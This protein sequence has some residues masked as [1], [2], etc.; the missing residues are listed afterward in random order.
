MGGQ[1]GTGGTRPM[2]TN[3]HAQTAVPI[4]MYHSIADPPGEKYQTWSVRPERFDRQMAWLRAHDFSPM[5]VT[6]L[7]ATLRDPSA[8]LPEKPVL[9]TFDDGFA[10][11]HSAALPILVA[12]NIPAT[13]YVTTGYVGGTSEWLN[14]PEHHQ[15]M[16]TW[17]QLAEVS[18]S[19]VEIGAHTHTHPELDT[20]PYEEAQDEITRPKRILE[21]RLGLRV[22][23]FAYPHGYHGPT[24]KRLVCEA[25]YTSACGVKHAMSA[26]TDDC[27]SLAR[28]IVGYD[29]DM[30]E[31]ASLMAGR[32]LE[33][34]PRGEK[35]VTV[36]WRVARRTRAMTRRY[37]S[38][39]PRGAEAIA[40]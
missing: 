33:I 26:T 23:S 25:G 29:V 4:L 13:L 6:G 10:D 21:D 20:L 11:F 37:A 38:R 7:V 39:S 18:R 15:P 8:R 34:A 31:F 24:V 19:G 32:G 36:G 14:G 9:V 5:T 35:L 1:R 16:L 3:T 2:S 22:T 30:T 40:G 12:H 27:F 28:I 17:Q